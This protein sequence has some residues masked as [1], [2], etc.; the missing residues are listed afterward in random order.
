[1]LTIGLASTV[2]TGITVQY[3]LSV[4]IT[5]F[6]EI[7]LTALAMLCDFPTPLSPTIKE[8]SPPFIPLVI[9]LPFM[10]FLLS[11]ILYVS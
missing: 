11:F 2:I 3:G 1:M 10:T 6:S 7:I 8:Q 5:E 4:S 9:P